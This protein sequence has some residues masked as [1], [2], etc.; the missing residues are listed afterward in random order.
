MRALDVDGFEERAIVLPDDAE[1][2]RHHPVGRRRRP[3]RRGD[4]PVRAYLDA[5]DLLAHDGRWAR[6]AAETPLRHAARLRPD[7]PP[8]GRLAAGFALVRYAGRQ[9]TA[10]DAARSRLR[11]AAVHRAIRRRRAPPL[12]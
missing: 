6:D 5:L 7:G 10:R 2:A 11:L 12:P 8:M 3:G 1:A 9:P 4:D